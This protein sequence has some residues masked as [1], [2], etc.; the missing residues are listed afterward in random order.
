MLF[1]EKEKNQAGSPWNLEPFILK[2]IHGNRE[3]KHSILEYISSTPIV[4][5]IM[6]IY[7]WEM[8]NG[9]SLLLSTIM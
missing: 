5:F 8:E 9:H 6:T 3:I 2:T 7:L 1:K 4:V